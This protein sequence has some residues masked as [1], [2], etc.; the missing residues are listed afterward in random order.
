MKTTRTFKRAPLALALAFTL[1]PIAGFAQSGGVFRT[2]PSLLGGVITTTGPNTNV[3]IQGGMRVAVIDWN[4]FNIDAGST[5]NFQNSVNFDIQAINVDLQGAASQINGAITTSGTGKVH[6]MVINP[7]GVNIGSSAQINVSGDFVAASGTVDSSMTNPTAGPGQ[8]VVNMTNAPI[9]IAPGAQIQGNGLSLEVSS[10]VGTRFLADPNNPNTVP[11]IFGGDVNLNDITILTADQS[12]TINLVTNAGWRTGQ[13]SRF[14][15]PANVNLNLTATEDINGGVFQQAVPVAYVGPT[16]MDVLFNNLRNA[17]FFAFGSITANGINATNTKFYSGNG[18]G[19]QVVISQTADNVSAGGGG[20]P[21]GDFSPDFQALTVGGS[22]SLRADT[23]INSKVRAGVSS[24]SAPNAELIAR[25]IEDTEVSSMGTAQNG[26]EGN[27]EVSGFDTVD[28]LKVSVSGNALIAGNAGSSIKDLEVGSISAQGHS[29]ISVF[30][31]S[32]ENFSSP[33]APNIKV[34]LE[35]NG[36]WSNAGVA[37]FY[38]NNLLIIGGNNVVVDQLR[39]AQSGYTINILSTNMGAGS[40]VSN[41]YLTAYSVFINGA[42][43]INSYLGQTS[44][45]GAAQVAVNAFINSRLTWK[46]PLT[47]VSTGPISGSS[48]VG[49]NNFSIKAPII[50][51][52]SIVAQARPVQGK[53]DTGTL[54]NSSVAVNGNLI[55]KASEKIQNS[56]I[57]NNDGTVLITAPIITST[58]GHFQNSAATIAATT[59]NGLTVDGQGGT[60]DLSASQLSNARVDLT[61]ASVNIQAAL[62]N[63]ISV[64]N[65][66]AI[67]VSGST[68]TNAQLNSSGNIILGLGSLSG[69]GVYAT[70]AVSGSVGIIDGTEVKGENI[71]LAVAEVRNLSTL[72]A[73]R[74]LKL[75]GGTIVIRDSKLLADVLSLQASADIAIDGA[76]TLDAV[77]SI[78]MAAAGKLGIG[79]TGGNVL[80]ISE[81]ITGTADQIVIGDN[82]ALIVRTPSQA[83]GS[84]QIQINGQATYSGNADQQAASGNYY[85]GSWTIIGDQ[86]VILDPP[87]HGTATGQAGI[88]LTARTIEVQGGVLFAGQGQQPAPDVRVQVVRASDV[89]EPTYA[90][91]VLLVP[92]KLA[93]RQGGAQ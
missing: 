41:S 39:T 81:R 27:V 3:N 53:I 85:N 49:Y 25:K 93:P 62:A 19:T 5:V 33:N 29:N 78:V 88:T 56:S 17:D 54:D 45:F 24:I 55:V 16:S 10:L 11:V 50:A 44:V 70:G 77:S 1:F 67:A 64:L 58:T 31:K 86:V 26:L 66:G 4:N 89:D 76:S 63:N 28:G 43:W 52:S 18:E 83:A 36:Y 37:A 22:A 72:N 13:R 68:W 92:G 60:L 38:A 21:I 91:G 57:T 42:S 75:T 14:F 47:M 87:Q 7:N 51:N 90:N 82:A 74:E 71:N 79:E 61:G 59:I 84:D 20:D 23:V 34:V 32:I 48:M 9:V 35:D 2:G 40:V 73:I 80:V 15:V 8:V 6:V 69:S 46:A 30:A 65:A 12:Q